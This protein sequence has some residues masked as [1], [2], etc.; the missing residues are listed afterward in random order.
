MKQASFFL[1]FA[2]CSVHQWRLGDVDFAKSL[3]VHLRIDIEI[4]TFVAWEG[5]FD[6]Y[7]RGEISKL[8]KRRLWVGWL[9]MPSNYQASSRALDELYEKNSENEVQK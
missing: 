8:F 7:K 5:S 3:S 1:F 6:Y 2:N 9:H 4:S